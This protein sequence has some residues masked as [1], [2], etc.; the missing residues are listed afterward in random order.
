MSIVSDFFE[1][2]DRQTEG[3]FPLHNPLV[4]LRERDDQGVQTD[5]AIRSQLIADLEDL[6][7][8]LWH[9][10]TVT[11]P[12]ALFPLVLREPDGGAH[13][14]VLLDTYADLVG[15][16]DDP[17]PKKSSDDPADEIL[18]VINDLL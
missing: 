1:K 11:T 2:Y 16:A 8:R 6:S 14:L 10:A 13:D 17:A 9:M 15:L 5:P 3:G 12:E 4:T 7:C 18:A